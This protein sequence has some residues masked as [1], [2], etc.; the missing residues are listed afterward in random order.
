MNENQSTSLGF[1]VGLRRHRP[2]IIVALTVA[3]VS[4]ILMAN[5]EG[6]DGGV[7][8]FTAAAVA[9][10]GGVNAFIARENIR[11][12]QKITEA[13]EPADAA[14]DNRGGGKSKTGR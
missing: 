11:R 1:W 3:I 8:V 2:A 9:I 4:V 12:Q 6:V 7:G 10:A 14:T 5:R 13:H